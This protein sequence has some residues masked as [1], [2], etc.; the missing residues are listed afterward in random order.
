MKNTQTKED[1]RKHF[2]T[3]RGEITKEKRIEYD[4]KIAELVLADPIYQNADVIYCYASFRDEVSTK[5][6][7]EK[8]L[9]SGKKLAIPRVVGRR[10]MEFC[11]IRNR[12]DL[13][14]GFCSI[15]EPGPWCRK[16]PFPGEGDLVIMPGSAFDRTGVRIGYGGGYYDSYFTGECRCVLAA[17]AYSIQCTDNLPSDLHDVSADIIFTEKELIRCT[18][19]FRVIR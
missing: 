14:P 2:L 9:D 6:I 3:L 7:I 4:K 15:P 10:K 17:L 18:Q 8:T 11:Y 16:A 1:I 19:D 5:E 13:R 12:V